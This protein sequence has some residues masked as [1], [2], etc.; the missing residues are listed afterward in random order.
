MT[1]NRWIWIRKAHLSP[2]LR[3]AKMFTRSFSS[4]ELN[5]NK[6][7]F[8]INNH[9][10]LKNVL[11]PIQAIFRNLNMSRHL[12]LRLPEYSID[13]ERRRFP[14]GI[15]PMYGWL[16]HVFKKLHSLH[17]CITWIQVPTLLLMTPFALEWQL[18]QN[19]NNW[20]S[21]HLNTKNFSSRW[22]GSGSSTSGSSVLENVLKYWLI[23]K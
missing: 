17:F 3:W 19:W 9:T 21:C 8:Y 23:I 13:P 18:G 6:P 5:R 16:A 14:A 1:D 20:R 12:L 10:Y 4:I 7:G 2:G 22:Q 15:F 11:R